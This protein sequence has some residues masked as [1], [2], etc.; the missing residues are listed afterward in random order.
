MNRVFEFFHLIILPSKGFRISLHLLFWLFAFQFFNLY[1]GQHNSQ[2][3]NDS[4]MV[5]MLTGV[6]MV[7]TYTMFYL[8]LPRLLFNPDTCSIRR[9]LAVFL[10]LIVFM[11]YLDTLIIYGFFYRSV[12]RGPPIK[13]SATN[14]Y[15]VTLGI[16]FVPLAATVIKILRHWF[17][18]QKN[19]SELLH[20]KMVAELNQLKSQIN[21]HFLFNTLNSLYALALKKS[22][23]TPEAILKLSGILVISFMSARPN[24]FPLK[25]KFNY[26]KTISRWRDTDMAIGL[27]WFSKI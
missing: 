27:T 6:S 3:Q 15:I 16:L 18:E 5:P 17:R 21:P 11:F 4:L 26:W 10:F 12:L 22:D 8:I 13:D 7:F 1:Y 24:V 20:E 14:I 19:A 9:L 23:Q 2:I 25:R